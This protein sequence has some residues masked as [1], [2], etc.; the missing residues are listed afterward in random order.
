MSDAA[1]LLAEIDAVAREAGD[2]IMKI[3]DAGFTVDIK[4]DNSPV[5]EADTAAEAIILR[6]L[7]RLTPDIPVVAEEQVA[8]HGA[9]TDVGDRFWLVDPLDGTREFLTHNDEFTVN[10]ALIEAQQPVLGVVHT[11]AKQLTFTGGVGLGATR[12]EDGAPAPITIRRPPAKGLTVVASRRHGSAAELDHFLDGRTIAERVNCGSSL[13][14]CL[15]ACGEADLYPRFGPT[16]EWDTAAGH[17][18]LAAAGGRVTTPDGADLL[19][20]KPDF[21]NPNFIAWGNLD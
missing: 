16:M 13:K 8:A 18:V 10:I 17:A 6:A 5:T 11:P 21:R 12:S 1:A 20:H 2:A 3:Y 15:V 14:F 4:S 19:Y 7:S 9:P